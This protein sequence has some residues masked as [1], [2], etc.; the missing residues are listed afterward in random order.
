M[1]FSERPMSPPFA[2]CLLRTFLFTIKKILV[3]F[4][5]IHSYTYHPLSSEHEDSKNILKQVFF[6]YKFF[7]PVT[8]IVLGYIGILSKTLAVYHSLTLTT[9]LRNELQWSLNQ[10]SHKVLAHNKLYRCLVAC[11]A[12]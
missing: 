3:N 9:F 5:K 12:A 2:N 7:L 6:A 8:I 11:C 10:N 4:Y 1:L